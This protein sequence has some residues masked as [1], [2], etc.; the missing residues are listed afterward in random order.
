MQKRSLGRGLSDLLSGVGQ[1]STQ[2]I[3]DIAP[4][5]IEPNPYQPRRDFAEEELEELAASFRAHGI[6]Q[7]L[8]VREGGERYQLI[9]GERRLRAARMVGLMTVPCLVYYVDD[10]QLLML[11][12]IENL[13]RQELNAVE[14]ARA[15]RQMM[16]QFGWT[17]ESVADR[18]GKSRPAVANCLRLLALPNEV[19]EAVAD[20]T[21]SEGHARALL[22][23]RDQPARLYA[24]CQQ[25]M[26]EGLNVRQ[27]E[28]LARKPSEFTSS[29]NREHREKSS[30][31]ERQAIDPYV[32]RVGDRIQEALA[33]KVSVTWTE[34]GA[35]TIVIR[36]NDMEELTRI[37]EHIAPEEAF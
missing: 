15:Y 4:D 37:M 34:R 9:A 19:L 33:T 29:L 20:G 7:P 14:E 6:L 28:E 22:G 26:K 16:E 21:I 18:V 12:L 30:G 10:Q 27:T 25:V 2:G 5:L 24:I 13:Q 8:L 31:T 11:A 32:E 35:G 17:Q 3:I 23:L 1:V 36:Y